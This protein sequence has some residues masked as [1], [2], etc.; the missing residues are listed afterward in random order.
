[1]IATQVELHQID[2]LVAV[3]LRV[4]FNLLWIREQQ[5]LF[6]RPAAALLLPLFL[7]ANARLGH[8]YHSHEAEDRHNPLI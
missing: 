8:P 2:D 6:I 5:R 7:E 1:M 4:Y 3:H